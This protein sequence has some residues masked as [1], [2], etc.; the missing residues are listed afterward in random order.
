MRRLV[1]CAVLGC[2]SCAS[3]K[4]G[5]IGPTSPAAYLSADPRFNAGLPVTVA[6]RKVD[7][8]ELSPFYSR[9]ELAP[10]PHRL[11]VDCNVVSSQSTVRFAIDLDAVPGEHYR[12]V[13]DMAPGNQHCAD[14]HVER[15]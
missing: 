11:L 12:L 4:V 6:L 9:A 13:A 15:H 2:T 8:V 5:E 7:S 10:G 1:L 14:V 3:V